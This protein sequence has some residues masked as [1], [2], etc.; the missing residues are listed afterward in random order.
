MLLSFLLGLS[1]QGPSALPVLFSSPAHDDVSPFPGPPS[2]FNGRCHG[3]FVPNFPPWVVICRVSLDWIEW[4]DWE[5][6][7]CVCVGGGMI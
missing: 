4:E 6:G 1:S 7:V 3:Y 2:D 5:Q